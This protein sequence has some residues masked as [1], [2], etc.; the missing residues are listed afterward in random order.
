VANK[1]S[2]TPRPIPHSLNPYSAELLELN[3][4][5]FTDPE[6]RPQF[7]VLGVNSIDNR[8]LSTGLDGPALTAI[9]NNYSY[10]NRGD[11]G[12]L[13]L[14]EKAGSQANA[15]ET[16]IWQRDFTLN[17]NRP[18]TELLELPKDLPPGTSFSLKFEPTLRYKLLKSL[19]R[20]PFVTRLFVRYADGY[21]EKYRLVPSAAEQ[22]PLVP[23][24]R[25]EDALLEYIQAKTKP[26][27]LSI[28]DRDTPVA[29][30]VILKWKAAGNAPP[31][32][33]YFKSIQITLQAPD[34][35]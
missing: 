33:R 1:L 3:R 10:R 13:V 2:Y 28:S 5:F 18:R 6:R 9:A 17:P 31:I 22:M 26:V 8:W 12:S 25:D 24:P 11:R 34:Q 30:K 35:S 32:S 4:A 27:D 16:V 14:E 19:Y 20:P 23:I 29:M 21:E 7:V 15:K